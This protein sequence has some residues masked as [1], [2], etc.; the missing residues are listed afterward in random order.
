MTKRFE[1]LVNELYKELLPLNIKNFYIEPLYIHTNKDSV[2]TVADLNDIER[3]LKV[4]FKEYAPSIDNISLSFKIYN[5]SFEGLYFI[6]S[7]YTEE[8][9][10]L[11]N[12]LFENNNIVKKELIV[13]GVSEN[14][15]WNPILQELEHYYNVKIN[16]VEAED[17]NSNDEYDFTNPYVCINYNYDDDTGTNFD[18]TAYLSK[19]DLLTMSAILSCGG[20]KSILVLNGLSLD[21]ITILNRFF[22]V[23]DL[24]V[25]D[26]IKDMASHIAS[27]ADVIICNYVN[28]RYIN[29]WE[30]NK[31]TTIIDL[32]FGTIESEFYRKMQLTIPLKERHYDNIDIIYHTNTDN[33][34]DIAT[35]MLIKLWEETQPIK[36]NN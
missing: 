23:Y 31:N 36:D 35:K 20:K 26:P 2:I 16:K 29:I 28:Y 4:L 21:A 1:D 34:N 11:V 24:Y 17:L 13:E 25:V 7:P 6:D 14:S 27:K 12:D 30:V 22:Y 5:D 15:E 8:F 32:T 9:N 19:S 33:V 18:E 3:A 10:T